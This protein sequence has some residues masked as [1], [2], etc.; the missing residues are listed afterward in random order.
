MYSVQTALYDSSRPIT[1][2]VTLPSILLDEFT[3]RHAP[4]SQWV[5][6]GKSVLVKDRDLQILPVRIQIPQDPCMV[7]IYLHLIHF[8][9]KP[10]K[11]TIHGS[12]GNT[13][14]NQPTGSQIRN[15]TFKLCHV[16]IFLCYCI[17]IV[18]AA[19]DMFDL[20]PGSPEITSWTVYFC[21]PLVFGLLRVICVFVCDLISSFPVFLACLPPSSVSILFSFGF[22]GGKNFITFLTPD[23]AGSWSKGLEISPVVRQPQAS[24]LSPRYRCLVFVQKSSPRRANGL[25]RPDKSYAFW[26]FHIYYEEST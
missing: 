22:C 15:Q 11:Y 14:T 17:I 19:R 25:K 5:V 7:R 16:P 20:W 26:M 12:Y 13:V 4:T 3:Y 10:V 2:W 9:G 23:F 8:Y 24:E 6:G 1:R 18:A 21:P